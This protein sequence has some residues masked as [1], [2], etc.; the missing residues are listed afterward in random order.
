MIEVSFSAGV[1]IFYN[2]PG[3]GPSAQRGVAW[4]PRPSPVHRFLPSTKRGA[5]EWDPRVCDKEL[6]RTKPR[7]RSAMRPVSFHTMI[8]NEKSRK[9]SRGD[10][11]MT[12][13]GHFARGMSWGELGYDSV[14]RRVE[15]PGKGRGSRIWHAMRLGR[16]SR[17]VKSVNRRDMVREVCRCW[18]EGRRN[19]WFAACNLMWG[20]VIS[21]ERWGLR[22]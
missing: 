3:R 18:L 9:R 16:K 22:L 7:E 11:S 14:I 20:G 2:V 4:E 6:R 17:A 13:T 5:L 19:E 10:R 1:I 8:Q 15:L 21:C 12:W